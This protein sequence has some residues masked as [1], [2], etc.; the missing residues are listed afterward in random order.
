MPCRLLADCAARAMARVLLCRWTSLWLLAHHTAEAA[1][2][3][4]LCDKERIA[5]ALENPSLSEMVNNCLKS[6]YR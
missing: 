4:Q 6:S 2:N 3:K 1:V 5:A